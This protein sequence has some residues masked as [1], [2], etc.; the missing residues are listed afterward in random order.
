MLSPVGG[1]T[2]VDTRWDKYEVLESL[3]RGGGKVL[4]PGYPGPS[5]WGTPDR[6]ITLCIEVGERKILSF[7]RVR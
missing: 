6:C 2:G 4:S 5:V 3:N 1:G 7:T